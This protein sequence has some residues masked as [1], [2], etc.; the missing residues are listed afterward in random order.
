M[1]FSRSLVFYNGGAFYSVSP[2]PSTGKFMIA[3]DT[4]KDFYTV[5]ENGNIARDKASIEGIRISDTQGNNVQTIHDIKA[6][7]YEIDLSSE[8]SGLYYLQILNR[9]VWTKL[10]IQKN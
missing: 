8:L 6:D 5:T 9:D 2:N 1:S 3:A 10:L 7:S 4:H